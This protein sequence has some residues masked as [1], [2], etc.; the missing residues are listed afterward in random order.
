MKKYLLLIISMVCAVTGAWGQ[1]P[2]VSSA[3]DTY[4][5]ILASTGGGSVATAINNGDITAE[6][7]KVHDQKYFCL[8]ITG[9]INSTDLEKLA[10]LNIDWN[11]PAVI[12][13]SQATI[14]GTVTAVGSSFKGIRVPDTYDISSSTI[15][16]NVKF[17]YSTNY[18]S[19]NT[20][21]EVNLYVNEGGMSSAISRLTYHRT[22]QQ[23]WDQINFLKNRTVNLSGTYT[24]S[25]LSSLKDIEGINVVVSGSGNDPYTVDGCTVTIN[26]AKAGEKS[27]TTLLGEAKTAMTKAD[28]TQT[29]ICTLIVQG[30][31][32]NTEL[33]ALNDANLSAVTKIDLS[34]ATIASG[35]SIE[36]IALPT[37][38][39]TL[40]QQLILPK[41]QTVSSTLAATLAS[42]TSLDYAY[43]PSSDG[44]ATGP[45]QADENNTSTYSYNPAKNTIAD[46]VWVNKAGGLKQ[47]FTNEEQLRNSFYIKV[48]S[49]VALNNTDV[50]FNGLGENKPTNYLFLDFSE[51]NLTPSVAANYTVTDEIGYRIILPDGWTADQMAVFA[52]L[53]KTAAS[54]PARGNIAAVYSYNGT[55]LDIMEIT[56]STYMPTAL[57]NPRIVRNGTTAIQVVGGSYNGNVYR[58]FGDNLLAAINDAQSVTSIKSVKISTGG[59]LPASS[60]TF[61]NN[62]IETLDLS[63]V[64]RKSDYYIGLVVSACSSLQTLILSD[65]NV[66][67]VNASGATSLTSVNLTGATIELNANF[68]GTALATF[69]TNNKTIIGNSTQSGNGLDLSGTNLTSF[70]TAAKIGGDINLSAC[71][72][73]SSIDLRQTTFANQWT[74]P[75]NS[76]IHIHKTNDENDKNVITSLGNKSIHVVNEFDE[77]NRICP[78]NSDNS[79]TIAKLIDEQAYVAPDC[80]FS[81]TDMTLHEPEDAADGDKLVYWYAG[82]SQ[83]KAVAIVTMKAESD[84]SKIISD[85]SLGNSHVKVKIV[86][87]L[88]AADVQ[89]LK[90]IN[91]TV[92]DL[93]EATSGVSGTTIQA[94]LAA[95]FDG[96]SLHENTKFL[97]AP[98]GSTR[99]NLINGTSLAGLSSIW[100]VVA[101]ED[102]IAKNDVQRHAL[103]VGYNFTSYTKK[104]GTLQAATVMAA[105]S[106]TGDYTRTPD[107]EGTATTKRVYLSS[108]S[109]FRDVTISGTVNAYD[110]CKS[111]TVDDYGHLAWT[112]PYT[113]AGIEPQGY[114]LTGQD[115]YGPFGSCFNLT[116]IDLEGAKFEQT[117]PADNSA[118]DY[119]TDMTLSYLNVLSANATCKVVIPTDTSVKT[120]P[121]DF[122]NSSVEIDA[123]CIPYNIERICARAFYT[124]DYVWTTSG[125]NDPEGTNT[126]LD[127]G[128]EYTRGGTTTLEYATNWDTTKDVKTNFDYT[129]EPTGGSYTFSSNLKVIET[130]AFAN[131]RPHVKDV[132]VLN[133][134]APECHVDAFN[135]VMYLGN[136]G[137]SPVIQ[138]GIIT[139]DSYQNNGFWITMLHY[140][141]QTS[142]PNVQRYTDPT[143]D[144]SIATGERDGKGATLYYP[145][146]SEFI[147]SYVQGTYGYTWNAWDPAREFGSVK[148]GEFANVT[149]SAYNAADQ[150]K[151]NTEYSN[152]TT[153][154][155]NH[156]YYT[157]YD[158]K[159]GGSATKPSDL[160]DYDKIYWNEVSYSNSGTEKQ[161]LY[162]TGKD[163][164]GW[165]QFTLNA[166]AANTTLEVEEFRSYITDNEWWTYCPTFDITREQAIILFGTDDNKIPYISKLLYVRRDYDNNVIALNFSDNLMEHKEAREISTVTITTDQ[167]TG[168][169]TA[170]TNASQHGNNNESGVCIINDA[171]P[172]ANDVVM[173]AG[174]PYMIKP[175]MPSGN[176]R[177]YQIFKN[178][179]EYNKLVAQYNNDISTLPF[180]PV[181]NET[182]YN[183]MKAAENKSGSEQMTL[184]KNGLYTVPVFVKG[185]TTENAEGNYP[186]EGSNYKKST[187]LKYTFVGSFYKS[188]LPG[189]CYFLG[190][191]S[192]NSR[193]KFYYNDKPDANVMRWNN[194][195]GIICPTAPSYTF[196]VSEASGNDPA[197]WKIGESIGTKT[198]VN[199]IET[200]WLPKD[201]LSVYISG[202]STGGA[203]ALKSIQEIFASPEVK[204]DM[205]NGIKIVS[206]TSNESVNAKV[207][208]LDGQYLGNNI[209]SLSKGVYIVNGKKY[210]VK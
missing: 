43:S 91:A 58:S 63:G 138:D 13:L 66:L 170:V 127:N 59:E 176:V 105:A 154:G 156:K 53:P 190:W 71:D 19:S 46:Y 188:F 191:D 15:P 36:N 45:N 183:V 87:P 89:D 108:I 94:L 72:Y 205:T 208:S 117:N 29:S 131:T 54:G 167:E 192:K 133:T 165:H 187:S 201:D 118:H 40:L 148:N 206:E 122:M 88:K 38:T 202:G 41:D 33:G 199:G 68:S 140:P 74:N 130:A 114:A 9:E 159:A 10:T 195:T 126:K 209:Q 135:T 97:I 129:E 189:N 8:V 44:T 179:D 26:M 84:L 110:L 119:V 147:R 85:N 2:S 60:F 102:G 124:I 166:Y 149:L 134:E 175:Y 210:V 77:A 194:E 50:D 177:M 48:A 185:T 164:R 17:A 27:F 106:S 51:S 150:A 125:T 49:S 163:Y 69:T 141:R 151:A 75:Y 186:I 203:P 158:V 128:A 180:K 111:T 39:P 95:E 207:Y 145:N 137:Y 25:E 116:T 31:V 6:T 81:A 16:N 18:T 103:P 200:Y 169:V 93:S 160:M 113:E 55:R 171:A 86:G 11:D 161:H 204:A 136:G 57:S 197:Q 101:T 184:I 142:T 7:F 24:P 52:A 80:E 76:K 174:V 173:S 64:N 115:V 144:Y 12:D 78:Y 65:A 198:T 35:S 61:T 62:N 168:E 99:E 96:E 196:T 22:Y 32:S 132:Y 146:Q 42:I 20:S 21:A 4:N 181:V 92:L 153:G 83:D 3:N 73:L 123:I 162:P 157:F 37:P 152:Y 155:D 5:V 14:D 30:E 28:A 121:A 70:S 1:G 112:R 82:D 193:A 182:L 143:R 178:D 67:S 100:S 104:S 56:D 107:I 120:I 79:E 98:D 109:T 139:R 172:E 34:G 47:A 23:D 90:D